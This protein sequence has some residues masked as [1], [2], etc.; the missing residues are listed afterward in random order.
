MIAAEIFTDLG[1]EDSEFKSALENAINTT[2]QRQKIRDYIEY[3][4]ENT[5]ETS[6][7]A[8]TPLLTWSE[9]LDTSQ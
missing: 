4:I 1:F 8:G 5:L 7:G 2:N 9:F 6:S 3:L